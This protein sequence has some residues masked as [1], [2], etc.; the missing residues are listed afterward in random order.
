MKH[1][2]GVVETI[3]YYMPETWNDLFSW[4]FYQKFKDPVTYNLPIIGENPARFTTHAHW[5]RRIDYNRKRTAAYQMME[6]ICED[7]INMVAQILDNDFDLAK[8]LCKERNYDA[9]NLASVLNRGQILKYL[10]LRGGLLE[11]RDQDGNTPLLN[12]V[13]NWQFESIKILVE[14]GAKLNAVDKYGKD[15]VQGAKDRNLQSIVDFFSSLNKMEEKSTPRKR[16]K[17]PAFGIDLQF[18]RMFNVQQKDPLVSKAV[19]LTEGSYYPFNSLKGS[20]LLDAIGIEK[21]F[22][23]N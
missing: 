9:V 5:H 13:K 6:A 18:E 16:M 3:T 22:E 7:D 2:F 10:L 19:M 1:T 8:K 12:A 21:I 23:K 17:Y 20:Y 14:N 15:A 4:D 11:D